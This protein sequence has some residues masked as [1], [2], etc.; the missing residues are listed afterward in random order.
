MLWF[1]V[2]KVQR[3][4]HYVIFLFN[5]SQYLILNLH[6]RIPKAVFGFWKVLRKEKKILKKNNFLIVDF[7]E[8]NIK[9]NIIKIYQ[10]FIYI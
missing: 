6:Y 5:R 8:K 7:I 10:R 4:G 1:W 9:K 2:D 3:R